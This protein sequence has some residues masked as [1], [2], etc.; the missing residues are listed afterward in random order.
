[1]RDGAG[2]PLYMAPERLLRVAAIE[3][4]CD[5]YSLG[6]TLYEALLL[7]KPFRVP[8][9]VNLAGVAPFLATAEPRH[10]HLVDPG[11]PEDLEA[12]IMKAMARDPNHRYDSA[13]ELAGDLERFVDRW[14]SC[15]RRPT[16]VLPSQP[17]GRR[18][19]VFSRGVESPR[20][21]AVDSHGSFP[22]SPGRGIALNSGPVN[23]SL[24]A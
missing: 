24:G 22:P 12:I 4:K 19:H 3:I 7:E 17:R 18:L 14:S 16:I 23:D 10:P 9:H 21:A 11:F 20:D 1:M 13:R 2:T 6:V 8:D 15:R 5:I